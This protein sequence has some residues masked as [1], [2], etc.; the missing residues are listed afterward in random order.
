[1][2]SIYLCALYENSLTIFYEPVAFSTPT[3]AGKLYHNAMR[4]QPPT[5]ASRSI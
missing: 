4:H 3:T 1:M 5:S 2:T